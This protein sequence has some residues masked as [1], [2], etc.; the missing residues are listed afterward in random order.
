MCVQAAGIH[1]LSP[2]KRTSDMGQLDVNGHGGSMQQAQQYDASTQQ[3]I[4][5]QDPLHL[6][7]P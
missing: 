5:S 6:Y 2:D 1:G 4:V 7:L 3:I